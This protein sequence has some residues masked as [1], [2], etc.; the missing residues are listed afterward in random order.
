M[1]RIILTTAAIAMTVAA[2]VIWSNFMTVEPQA[3]A[4]A[5]AAEGLPVISPLKVMQDPDT[6]PVEDW[7]PTN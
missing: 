1:S 4:K 6:L 2:I 5:A 7:R 3:A